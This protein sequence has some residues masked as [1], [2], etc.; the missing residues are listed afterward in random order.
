MSKQLSELETMVHQDKDDVDGLI[1]QVEA[2][3]EKLN[4]EGVRC[5]YHMKQTL[6]LAKSIWIDMEF[7]DPGY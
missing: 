6:S 4:S 3:E 2:V 1:S 5:C 7:V